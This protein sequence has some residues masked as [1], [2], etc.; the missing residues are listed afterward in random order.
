MVLAKAADVLA[1]PYTFVFQSGVMFLAY[2]G[3]PGHCVGR[4]RLRDEV[5]EGVTGLVC[6]PIDSL[7]L[8]QKIEGY[9]GSDIYTLLDSSRANIR[10]V[11]ADRYSWSSVR[12]HSRQ[13]YIDL[14]T[15]P[16]VNA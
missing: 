7:N 15:L 3:C 2:S 10:R 16:P 1:L 9:F 11:A 12:C 13:V 4:R 8:A 5:I 6:A 14:L